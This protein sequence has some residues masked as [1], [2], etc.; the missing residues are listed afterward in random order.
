MIKNLEKI[1]KSLEEVRLSSFEKE[2]MLSQMRA[3]VGFHAVRKEA[4]IRH[5][6]GRQKPS[7][8]S[9]I[10]RKKIMPIGIIIAL[11]LSG[12]GVSYAAEQAL[13]GDTLYPIKVRVNEEIRE[14]ASLSSEAK[15]NWEGRRAERRL[16]EVE[17][18]A[19][20]GNLTEELEKRLEER[21]E[22]HIEKINE[23][24]AEFE[25]AGN[26]QAIERLTSAL[27]T[28]LENHNE[29]LGLVKSG[30]IDKDKILELIKARVEE[31]EQHFEEAR[32]RMEAHIA[33]LPEADMKI[34]AENKINAAENR[35]GATENFI[36]AQ[37]GKIDAEKLADLNAD[38]TEAKTKL[39][40]AKTYLEKGEYK[41][42][43]M[44][45]VEAFKLAQVVRM[46]PAI[47]MRIGDGISSTTPFRNMMNPQ[48]S[49]MMRSGLD[50]DSDDD[51]DEVEIEDESDDDSRGAG[52]TNGRG[53][54][55][56]A[57][58]QDN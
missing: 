12:G 39:A 50:D 5:K 21:F 27:E 51:E 44:K 18:L 13:P 52:A 24:I 41:D 30:E 6:E 45:A 53:S 48:N 26:T 7:F 8:I 11:L 34:A 23:K 3:F 14:W 40:E 28:S 20:S 10:I 4:G 2:Q 43:F 37:D 19:L 49:G 22:T 25:E 31:R 57:G 29:I 16:E 56:D 58:R 17:R 36:N 33:G 35:I 42:A 1:I 15:A 32:E 9:L 47:H 38:L 55:D 46:V 54:D